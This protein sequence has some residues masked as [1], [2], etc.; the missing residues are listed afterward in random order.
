MP[1]SV[2]FLLQILQ[3]FAIIYMQ[4]SEKTEGIIMVKYVF[5]VPDMH[6]EHCKA[7]ITE[8]VTQL[9]ARH[10]IK[11]ELKVDLRAK[12]VELDA[13]LKPADVIAAL[14]DIGFE[15]TL[16]GSEK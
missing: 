3:E 6:C 2:R 13:A 1:M 11:P 8:A 7:S 5:S 4:I 16:K 15:A 10:G 12:T 14:D 9:A